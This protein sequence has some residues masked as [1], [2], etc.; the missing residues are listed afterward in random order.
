MEELPP[1]PIWEYCGYLAWSPEGNYL[2]FPCKSALEG[3]LSLFAYFLKT[4]EKLRLTAPS[5]GGDGDSDPAFS[6][7]GRTL[8]FVRHTSWGIGK[9]HLLSLT[10]DMKI[11]GEIRSL[12]SGHRVVLHPTW[13]ADGQEIIYSAGVMGNRGLWR[14]RVSDPAEPRPLG[15]RGERILTPQMSRDGRRLIYVSAVS[16]VSLCR[17][18]ITSKGASHPAVR[19]TKSTRI[20]T[21]PQFSPDGRRIAFESDLTGEFEIWT[22]NP[23]GSDTTQ[24]TM[25]R[26][27]CS[28]PRWFPDGR[29]IIFDS[30]DR[31]NFD[32]YKL[33]LG[34]GFP[35]RMTTDP[36]DDVTPSVSGDGRWV[37]FASRRTGQWQVWRMPSRGGEAT[38]LTRNGGFEP[39]ESANAQ[40]VYYLPKEQSGS[41]PLELWSVLA[42]GGRET[43]VL[44]SVYARCFIP[45]Q[46]GIFYTKALS[47]SQGGCSLQ[48]YRFVTQTSIEVARLEG[49][50]AIGRITASPDLSSFIYPQNGESNS[51]LMLVENFK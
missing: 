31:G 44:D 15:F 50:V 8:A 4:G 29:Q 30:N 33:A 22:C 47:A 40:L 43:K 36:A 11:I 34:G 3:P 45:A 37:Y 17:K 38:Q 6:P 48:L 9:L 13:T 2:V 7:D 39:I 26:S 35:V 10:K 19:I 51:D 5:G 21:G 32:I 24:V 28:W 41:A 23:D 16:G 1:F 46:N 27:H 14:M 49:S 20:S 25:L 12:D 42:A 18:D